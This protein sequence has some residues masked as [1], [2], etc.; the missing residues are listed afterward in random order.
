MAET[1]QAKELQETNENMKINLLMT[2][3]RGRILLKY[4]A[5]ISFDKK[6]I[7]H[8][9]KDKCK[10]QKEVSIKNKFDTVFPVES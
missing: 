9:L 4:N 5:G 2:L 10:F 1:K 6:L 3:L 7:A 8:L